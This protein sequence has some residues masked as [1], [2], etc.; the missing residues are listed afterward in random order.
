MVP[1]YCEY[2]TGRLQEQTQIP[3]PLVSTRNAGDLYY[4]RPAKSQSARHDF[5]VYRRWGRAPAL[6]EGD[7]VFTTANL[8]DLVNQYLEFD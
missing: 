3:K 8:S 1:V 6:P 5:T 7:V 2:K 4:L